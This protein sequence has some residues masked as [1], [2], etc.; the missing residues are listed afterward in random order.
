MT[1]WPQ[2]SEPAERASRWAATREFAKSLGELRDGLLVLA[3]FTY[4]LGYLSWALYAARHHMG[5]IPAFDTQY[6]MAGVVPVAGL[7][8]VIVGA[9]G[10]FRL[11]AWVQRPASETR[12]RW[13]KVLNRV[14]VT[15]VLL[16]FLVRLLPA[17]YSAA[18][19]WLLSLSVLLFVVEEIATPGGGFHQFFRILLMIILSLYLGIFGVLLPYEYMT[20]KFELLPQEWG[21]PGA[22]LVAFDLERSTLSAESASLLLDDSAHASNAAVARSAPVRL[23]FEGSEFL[24][25]FP[26]RV[27]HLRPTD[28]LR[29][30]RSAVSVVIPLDA[31]PSVKQ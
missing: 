2:I 29:L 22:R 19:F 26:T 4:L 13:T 23:V 12:K 3:S 30:K 28:V 11:N 17:P 14:A 6:L 27:E 1:I 31:A 5:L 18:S 20:S 7:T 16:G 8:L 15:G 9:W 10:L 24:Y 21:G 25:F